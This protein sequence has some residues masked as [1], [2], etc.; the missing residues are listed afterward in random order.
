MISRAILGFCLAAAAVEGFQ[1]PALNGVI[2]ARMVSEPQISRRQ[3]FTGAAGIAVGFLAN[4]AADAASFDPNTG[5]PVQD[6]KKDKLCGSGDKGC[7]PMTQAASILDKQK[8]VLAGS[9]TVAANKLSILDAE[10]KA[11]QDGDGKKKKKKAAVLDTPYVLRYRYNQHRILYVLVNGNS[12][13]YDNR[14][15]VPSSVQNVERGFPRPRLKT[16][17]PNLMRP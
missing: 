4:Q 7:Q 9:I 2:G 10:L 6:G 14:E 13:V 3:I 11:M 15:L 8:A 1:T 5:F 12:L 17:I 16:K